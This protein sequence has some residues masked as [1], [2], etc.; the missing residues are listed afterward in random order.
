M[1]Y[2][3]EPSIDGLVSL[4]A[5]SVI[6]AIADS[7]GATKSAHIV[8]TGGRTGL[9]IANAIDQALF[10]LVREN[11]SFEG[12][13]LHIWF[14]D[15]RF[16]PAESPERNDRTLISGFGMC[17]SHLVFH[18]V[19]SEGDLD[20]AAQNY[21]NELELELG[22]HPFAAVVLSLGED[23]HIASLFPHDFDPEVATSAIAVHNSPKPPPQRVS[24]SLRRF[25]NA[26]HIYIFALGEGKSAALQSISTGPVGLLEKSSPN[27]QLQIF[28]DLSIGREE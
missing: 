18:S 4:C 19:D 25:A 8:L 24:L 27:G 26:L 17:K 11:S 13:M 9:A 1:K 14:S 22:N 20:L 12:S 28:T 15:E 7:W 3:S 6:S 23:G 21:A 10:K 16:V 2:I 5:I